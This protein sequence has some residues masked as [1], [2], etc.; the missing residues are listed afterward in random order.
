[1][2]SLD[3]YRP[4]VGVVLF[5]PDGR[6]WLGRRAGVS[7]DHAW[8]FPPGGV[9][10]GEDMEAAARRELA[11]ETGAAT[12]TYLARTEGW[13]RY[14]FPADHGGSKQAQGWLGQ[15]QVWFAYRFD[16]DEAEFDLAAHAPIEFDDWR[17]GRL[18]EVADL[19]VPFKREAYLQVIE[20]FAP[21]AA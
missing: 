18:A 20:A 9:D 10:A 19:V 14:D 12:I 21:F 17:W 2:S 7:G 5:H 15:K 13:I 11:E 1:M 16:G 4:N 3:R 8:Q 6:V